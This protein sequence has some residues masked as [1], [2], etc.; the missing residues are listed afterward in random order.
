MAIGILPAL[1]SSFLEKDGCP[2]LCDPVQ[3][4]DPNREERIPELRKGEENVR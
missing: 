2:I 4:I 3:K 1:L